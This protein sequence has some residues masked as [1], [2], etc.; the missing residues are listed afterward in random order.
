M[1]VDANV[2]RKAFESKGH[3]LSIA[4]PFTEGHTLTANE[5]LFVNRQLAS[6]TTNILAS[7]LNREVERLN[8][9]NDK[10]LA[11]T[12]KAERAK[13]KAKGPKGEPAYSVADVPGVQE[14]YDEIFAAYEPGVTTRGSGG[15]AAHDPV[16]SIANSIAWEQLKVRLKAKGFKVNSVKAEKKADLVAQWLEK[17]PAIL[18]TAKAQF[19]A[20]DTPTSADE[21]LGDLFDGL[22]GGEAEAGEGNA[23]DD[24]N[25]DTTGDGESDSNSPDG[26]DGGLGTNTGTQSVDEANAD[27]KPSEDPPTPGAFA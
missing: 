21:D 2:E 11:S 15:G 13:A 23:S 22:E 17:N 16:Q 25:V 18:E 6:V 8:A 5:A 20:S 27:D 9:E 1:K 3:K 7:W 10:L 26:E 19:A 12:D 4:Q 24:T 14:K